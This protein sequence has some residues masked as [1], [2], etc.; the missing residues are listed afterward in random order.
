MTGKIYSSLFISIFFHSL[1]II[2]LIF[3]IKNSARD[4]KNLT[5]VTLI[6]EANNTGISSQANPKTNEEIKTIQE[7]PLVKQTVQEKPAITKKDETTEKTTKI[8]KAE[9]E[10]LQERLS[11]LRAKKRILESASSSKTQGGTPQVG[12]S[13]SIKGQGVSSSYLGLI[14][15]LIRQKWSIPETVPKNLEAIV[16]VRILPNGQVVIEGFE[17]HSGNAL[18]D[19]SVIKALKNSSP[20][21][22]P[23]GEVVVGLRFKP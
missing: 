7:K 17:K 18:F 6:Q 23:K 16:S 15:G 9:E 1:F 3:G 13:G 22:P 2:F 12:T 20:L 10:L 21:P 14:S 5:Y 11:A 8:T 19:S 4:F